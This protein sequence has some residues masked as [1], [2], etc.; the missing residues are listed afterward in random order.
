MRG[1]ESHPPDERLVRAALA[2]ERSAFAEVTRGLPDTKTEGAR[3]QMETR[4]RESALWQALLRLDPDEREAAPVLRVSPRA[5][6]RTLALIAG[7]AARRAAS[8][9]SGTSWG[10]SPASSGSPDCSRRMPQPCR[11][12][13]TQASS[14]SLRISA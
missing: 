8:W 3:E 2:G 13:T 7:A 9:P 10:Q 12:P 6:Q 5:T 1:A 4:E 11:F 14:P